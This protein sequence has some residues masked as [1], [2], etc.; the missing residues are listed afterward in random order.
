MNWI[1]NYYPK[2][3]RRRFS[4]WKRHPEKRRN[5]KE[6]GSEMSGNTNSP[7]ARAKRCD[8]FCKVVELGSRQYGFEVWMESPSSKRRALHKGKSNMSRTYEWREKDWLWGLLTFCID[9][10]ERE[11]TVTIWS[12][13]QLPRIAYVFINGL[14]RQ[15]AS[16]KNQ[17]ARPLEWGGCLRR[18][19]FT[20]HLNDWR[21]VFFSQKL[22]SWVFNDQPRRECAV[23]GHSEADFS[24]NVQRLWRSGAQSTSYLKIDH[25]SI[26]K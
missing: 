16:K 21:S 25:W 26:F 18:K 11:F 17:L 22:I 4:L 2:F 24:G 7:G 8:Q 13:F 15:P 9:N 14:T 23:V 1:S 6:V 20:L 12:I 5:W 10:Y 3:Y 19:S